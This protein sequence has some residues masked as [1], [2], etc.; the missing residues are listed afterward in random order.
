MRSDQM[1]IISEHLRSHSTK[2][3]FKVGALLTY[4]GVGRG[5]VAGAAP[6]GARNDSAEQ[7]EGVVLDLALDESVARRVLGGDAPA[8]DPLSV[9]LI[10]DITLVHQIEHLLEID[11]KRS[12]DLRQL[13]EQF[14]S[15]R[16]GAANR[17]SMKGPFEYVCRHSN[18]ESG[19][20]FS[21]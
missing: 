8:L 3:Y 4:V 12:I 9:L 14:L 10:Y 19:K 11:W 18:G 21:Y 2:Y 15:A 7:R 16:F 6:F 13:L 17:K 20:G 1:I 5:N